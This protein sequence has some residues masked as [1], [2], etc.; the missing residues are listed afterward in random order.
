MPDALV[1]GASGFVGGAL[2]RR[3]V[4]DGGD[5]RALVRSTAAAEAVERLGAHAVIGDLLDEDSLRGLA[6]ACRTVFHA[7]GLNATCLRRPARLDRVNVDGT[8]ALLRA[9]ARS[10]VRRVVY[11]SSAATIGEPAGTVATEDAPHRGRYLTAYERSKH[12]AEVAA[13]DEAERLG[14]DLVS[15]NP[16][17]VQG[18]GRAGGSARFLIHAL[19][20]GVRLAVRTTVSLVYVDDC[21]EAHLRADRSGRPGARYLVSGWT[22]PVEELLEILG[23]VVGRD[24][25]ARWVPRRAAALAATLAGAAWWLAGRDAPV[26]AETARALLHDHAVDGGKAE[27][28]LGLRYT[29]PAEWLT[30]TVAWFRAQGL[31][32]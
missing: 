14:L 13:L 29:P 16:S 5:V 31:L 8:V 4:A 2:V 23:I 24:I 12:R 25:R 18:P 22:A 21:V 20:P 1:T 6:D 30:A 3:L 7:A 27:R 17:S 28:D 26:C 15:V 32:E 11:T 9:A 19:R 10:N